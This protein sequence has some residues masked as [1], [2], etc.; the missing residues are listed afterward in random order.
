MTIR[1]KGPLCVICFVFSRKVQPEANAKTFHVLVLVATLT[2]MKAILMARDRLR[3]SMG[4]GDFR[5]VRSC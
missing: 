1:V 4:F 2:V 3:F 5:V